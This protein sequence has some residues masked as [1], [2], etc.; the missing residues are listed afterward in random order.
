MATNNAI[1]LKSS[2]IASYD[3]AGTFTALANPLTVANGGT[4]VASLTAYAVLCGGTTSTNPVQSIAGVGTAGQVLT[5]NGAG[6]LPTFQAP[7]GYVLY[8]VTFSA[9]PQDGITYFLSMSQAMTVYTA[10]GNADSRLYIPKAGTVT[11]CYGTFTCT[12]GSGQTSTLSIRL[13]NTTDTT[14]SSAIV[15]D[16]AD[17]TFNNAALSIAVAAGDYLELK[18]LC[19]TWTPTNPTVVRSSISIYIQ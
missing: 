7:G 1:N 19:P 4:G 15:M 16:A 10:S 2:G 14:V 11:A 13:N 5:S 17:N 9:S 18:I 8:I 6:A 12:A 3:A